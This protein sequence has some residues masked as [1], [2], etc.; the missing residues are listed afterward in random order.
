MMAKIAGR[1]LLDR[2]AELTRLLDESTNLK[3]FMTDLA[4]LVAAHME[5]DACSFFIY[6][7]NQDELVLQG[8]EGLDQSFVGELRFKSGEGITGTVM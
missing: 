5:A 1:K 6:D 8:T 4:R 3:V 2:T 7:E